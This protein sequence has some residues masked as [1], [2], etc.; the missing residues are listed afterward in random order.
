MGLA[1]NCPKRILDAKR[2]TGS[3]REQFHS[4]RCSRFVPTRWPWSHSGSRPSRYSN[5]WCPPGSLGTGFTFAFPEAGVPLGFFLRSAG[6]FGV[7]PT[8]RSEAD[9]RAAAADSYLGHNRSLRC[10][11][12]RSSCKGIPLHDRLRRSRALFCQQKTD[13]RPVP[14]VEHS[15]G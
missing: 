15:Y 3:A 1:G 9:R 12:R 14:Q 2:K 13:F 11:K 7:I 10:R 4:C 6:S 8:R 5:L